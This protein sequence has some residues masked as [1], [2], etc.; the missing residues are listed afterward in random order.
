[1][2]TFGG[3]LGSLSILF[4]FNFARGFPEVQ[5]EGELRA[6]TLSPFSSQ[7]PPTTSVYYYQCLLPPVH[8]ALVT[9]CQ[10][11]WHHVLKLPRFRYVLTSTNCYLDYVSVTSFQI[12]V[13][14]TTSG[15]PTS[16]TIIMS[17]NTSIQYVY[18]LDSLVVN[19]T[20]S[21]SNIKL[22]W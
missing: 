14:N 12:T 18:T 9:G 7:T 5:P 21:G 8:N 17:T 4:F 10:Q 15:I 3:Y 19:T 13:L 16:S 22:F 6:L 11:A 20:C 2:T 1:M